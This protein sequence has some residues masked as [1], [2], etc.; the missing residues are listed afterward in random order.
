VYGEYTVY[1][2]YMPTVRVSEKTLK[3]LRDVKALLT[4]QTGVE[5]SFDGVLRIML[6]EF[7]DRLTLRKP[8]EVRAY[9]DLLERLQ[10]EKG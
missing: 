7:L 6:R 3:M 5:Q 10:R 1:G 8:E 2:V 9:A 4:L